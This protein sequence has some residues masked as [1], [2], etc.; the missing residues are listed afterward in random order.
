MCV[1]RKY[2]SSPGSMW[3]A[4]FLVTYGAFTD[5]RHATK[6][7]RTLLVLFYCSLISRK[8]AKSFY[9]YLHYNFCRVIALP[10]IGKRTFRRKKWDNESYS[11][12]LQ[13]SPQKTFGAD[14]SAHFWCHCQRYKPALSLILCQVF[15]AVSELCC[16]CLNCL[17]TL[18]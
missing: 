4:H 1:D 16:L 3:H 13:I 5:T 14:V 10:R 7:F 6:I 15:S 8:P 9:I 2:L 12:L 11:I 17:L 18:T